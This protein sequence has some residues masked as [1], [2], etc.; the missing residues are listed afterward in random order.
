MSLSILSPGVAR[1][2]QANSRVRLGV[3]GCDGRHVTWEELVEDRR[4]LSP[5]LEGLRN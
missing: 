4:R 2:S 5:K 1:G 3:I